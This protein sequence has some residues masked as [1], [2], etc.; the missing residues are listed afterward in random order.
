VGKSE[1]TAKRFEQINRS[2]A[3]LE[4][5]E[6]DSLI[7]Q[8]HRARLVWNLLE[9]MDLSRFETEFKAVEHRAGRDPWSPCLLIAIWIY[10]YSR[11]LS[12]AREIERQCKYEPGLRWLT[13]LRVINH[14]TLSDFRVQ[15]GEALQQMFVDVLGMLTLKKLITLER[16]TVDGTKIRACVNK[17]SFSRESKIRDHLAVARQH[18]EE[19]QQQEQDQEKCGRR[20][21]A[22]KRAARE[23]VDRLAS[24]LEEIQRLQAERKE[25][26][27]KPPQVSTTDAEAQFMRTGDH[28]LA[29]CYN[30]QLTTDS[31]HTLIVGVDVSPQPSDAAHLVPAMELV[32]QQTGRY[33]KQVVADGDYTNRANV[34][35]MANRRIDFYG[36][37]NNSESA[38]YGIQAGYEAA[39]FRYQQQS[40]EMIC[41]EGQ[42]LSYRT[43]QVME[44]KAATYVFAA[45]KQVCQQCSKHSQCTPQNSFSRQGRA[46]SVL[47]E[48][49]RVARFRQKIDTPEGKAIYKTRAPIAEFPHAWLKTKF[50]WVRFRCRG[51]AKVT[52]EALWA[53]LA[54]NL[55]NYFRLI[56]AA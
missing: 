4:P 51:L 7:P 1:T 43:T 37:W 8:T 17:K 30:V 40:N 23:R 9:K 27:Q 42:R 16:V 5:V 53:C 18:L 12:S 49:A 41:P 33:P 19:L 55:Q 45:D 6:V 44:G 32:K 50:N 2:Q 36:S 10:S 34:I 35:D 39:V 28:G 11:G 46:V 54:Y 15:Q 24:A 25:E 38:A 13:G 20:A 56:Q 22:I 3:V 52:T 31:K 21:A 14:H 29:P 26:R 48:D 47:V